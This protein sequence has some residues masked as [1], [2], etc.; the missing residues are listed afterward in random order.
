MIRHRIQN[1]YSSLRPHRNHNPIKLPRH[2]ARKE[3]LRINRERIVWQIDAQT[4]AAYRFDM[5]PVVIAQNQIVT[6]PHQPAANDPADLTRTHQNH[7]HDIQN[8]L[9][10]PTRS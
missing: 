8:S 3:S 7:P 5:F 2:F 10:K 9:R 6:G 4:G 1:R